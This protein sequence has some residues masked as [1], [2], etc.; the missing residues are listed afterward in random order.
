MEKPNGSFVRWQTLTLEHLGYLIGLLMTLGA[1]GL[2]FVLTILMN[3]EYAPNALGRLM[4]DLALLS[5][6]ISLVF[7]VWCAVNR[8]ADFRETAAIARLREQREY[9]EER[10]QMTDAYQTGLKEEARRGKVESLGA[11]TWTLFRRQ[12]ASFV[13]GMGF[14]AV[15]IVD[16]YFAKLFG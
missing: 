6:S 10:Q 7:G 16:L 3:K 1:A 15:A 11:R 12:L 14:L 5:L 13:L 4:V 9:Q 2:G 8:L